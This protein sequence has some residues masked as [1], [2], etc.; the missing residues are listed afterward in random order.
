MSR[1]E[2]IHVNKMV[3]PSHLNPYIR[4]L[5]LAF[6]L[7]FC[8]LD[9]GYALYLN[10]IKNSSSTTSYAGH[11]NGALAG[12]LIGV[13]IL[14]NRK[15]DDWEIIVQ[16]VAFV[17]YGLIFCMFVAWQ[18]AGTPTLWFPIS[19]NTNHHNVTEE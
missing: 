1:S 5:R 15:V 18:I 8:F 11:A 19:Q 10:Y 6:V 17:L 4:G 16:S 13:F 3:A 14:K 7:L 2:S 9:I 12:L